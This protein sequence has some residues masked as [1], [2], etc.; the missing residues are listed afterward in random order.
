MP[1]CFVHLRF[2]VA[3]N[4]PS[5]S[6]RR[7]NAFLGSPLASPM[8]SKVKPTS[9]KSPKSPKSSKSMS[10]SMSPKSPKTPKTLKSMSVSPN[11]PKSVKKTPA[12]KS[13]KTPKTPPPPMKSMKAVKT[14][15]RTPSPVGAMKRGPPTTSSSA[16]GSVRAKAKTAM[17][18]INKVILHQAKRKAR[19]E[20]VMDKIYQDW[21]DVKSYNKSYGCPPPTTWAKLPGL[22]FLCSSSSVFHG[23]QN[24][25]IH[26]SQD[27]KESKGYPMASE[28]YIESY[29]IALHRIMSY[30][31]SYLHNISLLS[32]YM[33]IYIIIFLD[34]HRWWRGELENRGYTCALDTKPMS[35][36]HWLKTHPSLDSSESEDSE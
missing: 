27:I 5:P 21:E 15:F 32:N 30:H 13:P 2:V 1:A 22:S 17:K 28:Y 34:W 29:R 16:S 35:W 23:N 25:N 7:S 4:M 33:I 10:I 8:R 3:F 6:L 20:R 31:I 11:S 9:P 14:K 36:K 26:N 19:F 24:Y 18:K 12:P